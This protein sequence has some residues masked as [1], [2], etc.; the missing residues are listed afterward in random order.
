MNRLFSRNAPRLLALLISLGVIVGMLSLY[1]AQPALIS[2]LDLKIYDALL[3]LRAAPAPFGGAQDPAQSLMVIIDIDEASLAAQG[4]WPWPRYRLADLIDALNRYRVAAIGVDILFSEADRA[5]PAEMRAA[6]QRDR[7]LDL[8]FSG[9]PPQLHDYDRIF[10]ESLRR[11][12]VVLG[13]YGR[14][15]DPREAKEAPPDSGIRVIARGHSDDLPFEARLPSLTS[16]R[17]PHET[18]RD[19][20]PSGFINVAPDWDGIVRQAPLLMRIGENVYPSLALRV[21]MRALEIENIIVE[22]GVDGLAA[23][24]VG[25]YRVPVSASGMMHIPFIGPRKTYPY[26]SARDILTGAL[27]P[28]ALE[29]RVVF[30]GTSAPALLDIRATPLDP[31]YPGVEIHAAV[32]DAILTQNAISV[33]FWT[34]FLQCLAILCAGLIAAVAFGVARPRVYLPLALLLV[35][36]AILGARF[37]FAEGLFVS[38]LYVALTIV[39]LGASLLFLRFWQEE[40]QKLVLRNAFS[41]YVSPE[42]VKRITKARGDLLA[43]EEREVSILFT[44]IRGFTSISEQLTPQQIVALLNRY[45][46]PMTALVRESSGTVDKFIGDALMTFWNAPLDVPNHAIRAV[47]AALAMQETL[48]R[49]RPELHAEFGVTI[50]IGAGIHT[51]PVYVGNMGTADTVNYTLIGDNVN[52]ASRLESLC[53][54]YGVPVIVSEATMTQCGER[55]SFQFL[56]TLQVKGKQRPVSIYQPMPPQGSDWQASPPSGADGCEKKKDAPRVHAPS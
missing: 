6:L 3:P 32:I 28:D 8:G 54:Q 42:I 31:I 21:L 50:A 34:P 33:P 18:L 53:P 47:S 46:T 45:F 29:G 30:I 1:I 52:L 2:R 27:P 17:Q 12:P 14:F 9:L 5:S 15:D 26:I 51:G 4:Q 41:H 7:G 49:L 55:F 10:A 13:M 23:V 20:A 36:A 11:A 35:A 56:D 48:A 39:A 37:L 44:D 43:G 40:R 38:P 22:S 19:A 24:R 25:D 16:I